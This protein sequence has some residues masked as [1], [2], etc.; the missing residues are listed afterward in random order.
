LPTSEIFQSKDVAS[1]YNIESL[2][3]IFW[4]YFET[5]CLSTTYKHVQYGSES[6]ILWP[7]E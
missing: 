7:V 2:I 5:A 4:M 3:E 1:A 6:G